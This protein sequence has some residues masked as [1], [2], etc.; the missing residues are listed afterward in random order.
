MAQLARKLAIKLALSSSQGL[1]GWR[2]LT[3]TGFSLTDHYKYTMVN[4]Y[5][6]V[7]THICH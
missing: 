6:H 4:M 3:P 2:E 7:H 1:P 5:K